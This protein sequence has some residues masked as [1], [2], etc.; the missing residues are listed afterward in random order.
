MVCL[1]T[2]QTK[3]LGLS[4]V[5]NSAAVSDFTEVTN[6]NLSASQKM[7]FSRSWSYTRLSGVQ[8][9]VTT[10]D[11]YAECTSNAVG[12][13]PPS[14]AWKSIAGWCWIGELLWAG[15]FSFVFVGWFSRA[16]LGVFCLA[17]VGF[18]AVICLSLPSFTAPS[19]WKR[20]VKISQIIVLGGKLKKASNSQI[21]KKSH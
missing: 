19:A 3:A 1:E 9:R 4:G 5:F 21:N 10:E 11:L 18:F 13:T 17:F 16:F 12:A 14:A 7:Y 8:T 6:L 2:P 15:P 20:A